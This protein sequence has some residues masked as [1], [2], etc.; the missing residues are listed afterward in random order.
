[1]SVVDPMLSDAESDVSY[2]AEDPGDKQI[3]DVLKDSCWLYYCIC[4]GCGFASQDKCCD[5][6]S[7][8]TFK[9]LC[10]EGYSGTAPCWSESEG[11]CMTFEKCCCFVSATSFPPGGS[12]GDGQPCFACCNYRCG[13]ESEVGELES[14]PSEVKML[15]DQTFLCYYCCCSGF[16]CLNDGPMCKGT[17][18]VCCFHS[19]H[20]TAPCCGDNGCCYSKN[21]LCCMVSAQACPPG[22]GK[23][24]GIPTCACCGATCGGEEVEKDYAEDSDE[25]PEQEAM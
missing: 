22:G 4:S 19:N 5:P 17:S 18:K 20:E 24:D 12:K 10:C 14:H 25:A 11:L 21:K 3:T 23:S 2:E 7:V 6:I 9:C 16:G 8:G 13:G 1:M 15:M